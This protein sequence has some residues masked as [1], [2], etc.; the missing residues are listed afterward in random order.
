MK[1]YLMQYAIVSV[2]AAPIR[3]KPGHRKE[4]VNQLLFGES[5]KVLKTKGEL[6]VKIQNPHPVGS[7]Q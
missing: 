5:V 6:W 7:D 1:L 3:K 4:M 2:P